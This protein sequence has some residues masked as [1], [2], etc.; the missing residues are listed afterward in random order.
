MDVD[1]STS[2][3]IAIVQ[4]SAAGL[5]AGFCVVHWAW[6]RGGLRPAGAGW[7]LLWSALLA[8]AFGSAGLLTVVPAGTP[9][10]IV[11]FV[12][13]Q[14]LAAAVL[15]ALPA[16]R[17][18]SQG[19]R[20]RPY[21]IIAATLLVV[22]ATLWLVG[23][24]QAVSAGDAAAWRAGP[25]DGPT[26]LVPF[27]VVAT[28]LVVALGK[29]R[30]TAIGAPL[31]VSGC[32]SAAALVAS[33]LVSGQ[34]LAE[35]L[36][37]LWALPFAFGLAALGTYQLRRTQDEALMQNVMRD[38]VARITNAAWFLKDPDT[39]LVRARDESRHILADPTIE[40][41]LRPLARGRF[42]TELYSTSGRQ[43]TPRERSFLMDLSQIVSGVA[44][45]CELAERLG[46]AAFTDSLTQ[47]PNRHALEKTLLESLD[48]ADVERTRVAIVYCDID[49]FK[50]ANDQH[51][52]AWGDSLLVQVADHLRDMVDGESTVARLGGDE[53]VM[54]VPRA[55]S[56]ATL[57]ELGWRI[58]KDFAPRDVDSATTRLSVGVAVRHPGAAISPDDLVR[59]ADM[60][61]LEAKR[62]HAG[63]VLY[64]RTLRRRVASEDA[65]RRA[66]DIGLAEDEFFSH[67]QPIAD[68]RTLEVVGLEA[69]ARWSHRG[70]MLMPS[71]WLPLAEE[72]GLIV[73]IGQAL[74]VS[75]R[76]GLDRFRLPIAVNIA[77]RQ[78]AEPTFLDQLESAWG[79]AAWDRLTIEV[80][81]SA[82]LQDA[83][84]ATA[85]LAELRTRGVRI[86]L[87]D[88]GTGY[89]SL[90]RLAMLPVDILKIDQSF[91]RDIRTDRGRAVLSA[92][93]ALADA[94]GLE[95][96]AEGV[97]RAVELTTLVDLGV[98]Y[99][100]GNLLGPA[101]ATF[102]VRG[103]RPRSPKAHRHAGQDGVRGGTPS[104]AG[105]PAFRPAASA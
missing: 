48:R 77:A 56:D 40:G 12:Q 3:W 101:A 39:V 94:H 29:S 27:A 57:L 72:S 46:R 95:V 74:L 59:N 32:V 28:Y 8:V 81:E 96:I 10:Q 14:L 84:L 86:S 22:R 104:V 97:E 7:T 23:V 24:V 78:L 102:P 93:L 1:G 98:T 99:V 100:Q 52:H 30:L 25:L 41:S 73:P 37:S 33:Y 45:R 69:L 62:T 6:W 90:S 58:R 18:Y 80:T 83:V 64:D 70:R 61:M 92:I 82:L 60:A 19:P 91:V 9:S 49:G 38:A 65:L 36:T 88:F 17:A 66:L 89:S 68:A 16:T 51:G 35:I 87:D 4:F 71:E 47:L 5:I 31:L 103:P 105:A 50:R 44:E 67:Y 76:A 43:H 20:V 42:V 15:V 26:F 79:D 85:M 2:T 13:A 63:V 55:R 75:S 54:L 53:F 21:V 11:L 34:P